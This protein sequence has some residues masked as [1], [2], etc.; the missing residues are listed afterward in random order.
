MTEKLV[1]L[2]TTRVRV[3]GPG[4]WTGTMTTIEIIS[5]GQ[6]TSICFSHAG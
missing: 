6:G 1:I 5:L 2:L 3:Y 4:Q